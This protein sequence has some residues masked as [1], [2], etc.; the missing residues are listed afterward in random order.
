MKIKNIFA[1][2]FVSSILSIVLSC[3]NATSGNG[4]TPDVVKEK[5]KLESLTIGTV[6]LTGAL[7]DALKPEGCT[8][9]FESDFASPA[10]ITYQPEAGATVALSP[11]EN[12]FKVDITPRT[13]TITVTKDG[14]D[15]GVYKFILSKK[16]APKEKAKLTSLS[17]GSED[18]T[19]DDLENALKP[20]GCTKVFESSFYSPA[21]VMYQ[22]E[23]NATVSLEPKNPITVTTTPMTLIITV[24]KDGKDPGVYKFILSKKG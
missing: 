21:Y 18:L 7:E 22:T 20:E 2:V 11:N 12:P 17:I 16:E 5:A 1:F 23:M 9:V 24:T 13:L 19:S 14:K 10:Q 4:T 6:N 15:P 8:K 3:G